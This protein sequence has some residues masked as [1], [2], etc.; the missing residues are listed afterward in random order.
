MDQDNSEVYQLPSSTD[1][2][3]RKMLF[4]LVWFF[5][6]IFVLVILFVVYAP[7]ILRL[8]PFSV[9]K[10]F[11]KPY[12]EIAGYLWNEWDGNT[13]PKIDNYLQTL[14][15]GLADSMEMPAEIEVEVHFVESDQ[16]N[17]FA[18]LGGHVFI[19]SGLLESVADENSLSMVLAHEL[20]HQLHRDPITGMSRGIAIQIMIALVSGDVRS[21]DLTGV[22]AEL[23]LL[24]FSRE[25]EQRA[26]ITAIHALNQYYGHV[27]G[28]DQF[29]RTI[30]ETHEHG[31][32]GI[33]SWLSS[34]PE[35]ESRIEYLDQLVEE[36]AWLMKEV[37]AI[38]EEI[39]RSAEVTEV[40]K[41]PQSNSKNSNSEL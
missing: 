10:N 8:V 26:D 37:R 18:T 17:A 41:S 28:Y 16:V 1:K 5:G 13:Y 9:E 33:P 3:I 31:E 21:L 36:N 12:E 29:F 34:H 40:S 11:V 19:T 22:S 14:A 6:I 32:T 25:Q 30:M 7:T 20:A 27:S 38:P 2:D 35:T 15:E 24:Y 4:G 23:G 39:R